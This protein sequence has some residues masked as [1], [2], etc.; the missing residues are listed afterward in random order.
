MATELPALDMGG[1]S[2]PYIKVTV[3]N[4]GKSAASL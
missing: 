4:E 2:D 1:T 3:V